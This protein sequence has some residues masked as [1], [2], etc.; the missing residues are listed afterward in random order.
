MARRNPFRPGTPSYERLHLADLNR[1]A[2]LAQARAARATRPDARQRAQ[3]QASTARRAIRQ[4]P[5]RIALAEERR[6][7]RDRLN[8]RDQAIFNALSTGQQQ[9]L[10]DVGRRYPGTVPAS[11]PDPFSE[12]STS[13]PR[14]WRLYYSTR[15]GARMPRHID[16]LP[17]DHPARRRVE[18]ERRRRQG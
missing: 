3:R 5:Q 14:L 7:Y 16:D 2:A 17:L 11:L 18:E 10:V 1:R 4:M 6:D 8:P 12:P 9:R 15:G 13:R